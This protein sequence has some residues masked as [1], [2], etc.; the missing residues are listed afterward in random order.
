MIDLAL[1]HIE[2]IPFDVLWQYVGAYPEGEVAGCHGISHWKRV[3]KYG[4]RIA[5]YSG[6]DVTVVRLFALFHDA[7][8]FNNDIDVEHGPLG[9]ELA[10]ELHNIFY[11][12]DD[13]RFE[14]LYHACKYHADGAVSDDSTI[15]TCWDADRLDLWR[16][17]A[18]PDER[19]MSTGRGKKLARRYSSMA[20]LVPGRFKEIPQSPASNLTSCFEVIR[21]KA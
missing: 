4:L 6:A 11:T 16:V 1:D 17:H 19:Y 2:A 13:S 7:A 18:Q 14:L 9:A 3:E 10:K 21:C 12:L 20:A 15:G 8:R 5:R